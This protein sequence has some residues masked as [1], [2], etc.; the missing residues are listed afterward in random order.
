MDYL[1][2]VVSIDGHS[3]IHIGKTGENIIRKIRFDVTSW[4]Q[5]YGSGA[6]FTVF[7]ERPDGVTYPVASVVEGA[8]LTITISSTETAV[9][10]PG[11][12]EVRM[13]LKDA[14]RKSTRFRTVCATSLLEPQKPPDPPGKSWVDQ[15]MERLSSGG[16]S[17]AEIRAA[18]EEYLKKHG[19]AGQ[20]ELVLG[21]A[22]L[23]DEKGHLAVDVADQNGPD[24]S[25]PVS[26]SYVDTIVGNIEVLLETI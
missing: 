4:I 14:I 13:Y 19:A 3:S 18:V 16:A 20:T 7:F 26:G 10:G 9:G 5:Q 24:K 2:T 25:K 8:Y 23:W 15:I 12:F 11:S 22:L 21:R 6:I 17:E 1:E